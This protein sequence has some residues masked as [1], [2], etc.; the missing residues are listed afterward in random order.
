M[1]AKEGVVPVFFQVVKK[2]FINHKEHT[3]KFS[4]CGL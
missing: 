3:N 4:F 1:K 2:D